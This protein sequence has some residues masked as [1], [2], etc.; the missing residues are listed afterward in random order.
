VDMAVESY[1]AFA[2]AIQGDRVRSIA[3]T[4]L[5]HNPALPDVPTVQ[6]AGVENYDVTGWNALYAPAGTPEAVIETLHQAVVEVTAMPEIQQTFADLGTVARSNTPEEMAARFEA[7][8]QK[9]ADV[10]ESAGIETR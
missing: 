7:D 5:E 2:S 8:R 1:T 10:I 6:E 4:G 3:V 9:W